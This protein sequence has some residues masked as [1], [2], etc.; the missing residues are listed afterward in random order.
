[1]KLSALIPL[2][3]AVAAALILAGCPPP[4]GVCRYGKIPEQKGRVAITGIEK[5]TE[6]KKDMVKV[7]VNGFFQRAFYLSPHH[8]EKCIVTKGYKVGSE[9]AGRVLPGGPCPPMYF[10]EDCVSE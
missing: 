2:C 4:I 5:I 10:L 9:L 6:G 7:S 3:A 8:Y 1:M